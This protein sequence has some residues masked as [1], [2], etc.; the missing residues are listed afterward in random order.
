MRRFLVICIF[1]AGGLVLIGSGC[2]TKSTGSSTPAVEVKTPRIPPL[3]DGVVLHQDKDIQGVWLAPGFSFDQY[4]ALYILPTDFKAV[5][6]PNEKEMRAFAIVSL[7]EQFQTEA[8]LSGLYKTVAISTN[9][10]PAGS[11]CLTLQNTIIEYEKGGGG[12]R[13]F[14]GMFGAGQPVIKVRGLMYDGDRLVFVFEAKRSGESP[15][16]R[17]NDGFMSDQDIQQNDIRDL[18]SDMADCMKRNSKPVVAK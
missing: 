7:Q 9:D 6:R 3:P 4:D 18:T 1:C 5:E 16:A 10:I 8:R 11:R 15:S 2:A 14:A 12:A 13:Y 17:L